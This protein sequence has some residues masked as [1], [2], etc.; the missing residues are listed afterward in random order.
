MER[1]GFDWWFCETTLSMPRL[2]DVVLSVLNA[3]PVALPK[4][5]L[6]F[7]TPLRPFAVSGRLAEGTT[8]WWHSLLT[9][10]DVLVVD[11]LRSQQQV[12]QAVG[13]EGLLEAQKAAQRLQ[14]ALQVTLEAL[15]KDRSD[16]VSETASEVSKLCADLEVNLLAL[17]YP[18]LGDQYEVHVRPALLRRFEHVESDLLGEVRVG[19]RVKIIK[20]GTESPGRVQVYTEEALVMPGYISDEIQTAQ[21]ASP[22]ISGW[23]SSTTYNGS[24]LLIQRDASKETPVLE[25]ARSTLA[26][27]VLGTCEWL[28]E[29]EGLVMKK[30][31]SF[32]LTL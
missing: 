32:S 5:I 4:I 14:A 17:D 12:V 24:R 23:I 8:W 1:L 6:F 26:S 27:V 29:A 9:S 13:E 22:G 18:R 11:Q 31:R 19:K 10:G 25:E 30:F 15:K 2:P 16:E 21:P 7:E 20:H 3:L 28:L